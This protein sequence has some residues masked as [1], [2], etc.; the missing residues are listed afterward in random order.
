MGT[1]AQDAIRLFRDCK[2]ILRPGRD[3]GIW[4]VQWAKHKKVPPEPQAP[5]GQSGFTDP[6]GVFGGAEFHCFV[7]AARRK[8]LP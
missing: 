1:D 8:P 3:L 5:E 2:E 7:T 4:S 6:D